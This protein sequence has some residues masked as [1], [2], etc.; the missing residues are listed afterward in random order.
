LAFSQVG[1][2]YRDGETVGS[3]PVSVRGDPLIGVNTTW[4]VLA[5]TV[6]PEA[7]TKL[8]AVGLM[9]TSTGTRALLRLFPFACRASAGEVTVAAV[10]LMAQ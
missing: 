8:A 6:S 1:D 4:Y 10:L 9:T 2:G 7:V 5:A 3:V